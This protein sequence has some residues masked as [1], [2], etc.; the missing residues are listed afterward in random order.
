MR[1]YNP[2]DELM[3]MHQD[4]DRVFEGFMLPR[5]RALL[6]RGEMK[7]DDVQAYQEP[8]SDVMDKGDSFHV[9]LDLPGVN[10]EDI[11]ITVHKR[12]V[13]VKAERE[14]ES[15]EEK[16]SYFVHERGYVGYARSIPLP[17]DIVPEETK[18]TYNNGLL[19]LTLKKLEPTKDEPYKVDLN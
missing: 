6:G 15:T 18:A 10:K 13:D 14:K 4:L 1:G 7:E 9:I 2:W 11:S 19:E 12:S 16:E 5:R 17:K 3:R 8:T